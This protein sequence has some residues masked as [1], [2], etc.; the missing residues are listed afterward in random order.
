M[1]T[2]DPAA[3]SDA[4]AIVI[5]ELIRQNLA[6]HPDKK[7]TLA[8]MRGRVALVAEDAGTTITLRFR[9]GQL[10][11][12]SGLHGVPDLVVRGPGEALIDLSRLPNHPRLPFLPDYRSPVARSLARALWERKL[13]IRGL[14]GHVQLFV[15][16]GHVL[17]IH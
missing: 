14:S 9:D 16:L 12:H 3:E 5:S 4:F 15:R 10:T 1:V 2:L 7:R 8:A 13:R 6:D 11:V 17:S